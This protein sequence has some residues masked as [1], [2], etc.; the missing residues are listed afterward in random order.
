MVNLSYIPNWFK[1]LL[2]ER[3]IIFQKDAQK[4]KARKQGGGE[5][6]KEEG[7]KNKE[8]EGNNKEEGKKEPEKKRE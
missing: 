5:N 3:K 7:G 1:S 2:I 8:E 4:W 6:N